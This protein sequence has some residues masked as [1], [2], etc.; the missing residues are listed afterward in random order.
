MKHFTHEELL[1]GK[2]PTLS[3]INE[4]LDYV[5]DFAVKESARERARR[6]WHM[7]EEGNDE[8]KTFAGRV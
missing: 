7:N 8:T 3:L 1:A 5:V 6:R 2:V 4:P